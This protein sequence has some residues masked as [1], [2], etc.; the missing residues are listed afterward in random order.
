MTKHLRVCVGQGP[1]ELLSSKLGDTPMYGGVFQFSVIMIPVLAPLKTAMSSLASHRY[2]F[3]R[4]GHSSH[5][6]KITG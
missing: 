5:G 3:C 4:G 6:F 2:H 1:A